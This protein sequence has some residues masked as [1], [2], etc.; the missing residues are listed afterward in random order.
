MKRRIIGGMLQTRPRGAQLAA[1]LL[2]GV[3]APVT[4][5]RTVS[6]EQA[7]APAP[8]EKSANQVIREMV[9]QAF[10]VLRDAELKTQPE[11]RVKKLREITDKA[12]DWDAMAKSSL[13]HHWRGLGEPERAEFVSIFKELL[14]RQ[15]RDDVDRFRGSESVA[16][17]Q[18]EKKGELVTVKTTLTT[19]SGEKVP[20]NYTLHQVAGRWLCEDV[21]VE[22]VS[23]TNHYRKTF[24]RFLVNQ[25]F[26]QLL[27]KLKQKLGWR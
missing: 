12:M 9:D 5:A 4:V 20:I 14:A 7:A 23:M 10:T 3:A 19:A 16:F 6:A 26:A 24:D 1:I 2:L 21:S 25:P 8:A 17:G 18:D 11:L 22:G 15:Y 27:V 13:G